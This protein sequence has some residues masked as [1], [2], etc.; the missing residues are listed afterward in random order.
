[1]REL[2]AQRVPFV[3]AVVVRAQA[4]TSV[5][6]G[7][8]AIV[9]PDGAMEGFVGGQCTE[10]S[11]RTAALGALHD[12]Q[13]V[14]LRVL[15]EGET[16]FPDA[17]GARVVINP[18][19]SGGAMEVFLEP[20]LPSPVV[21]IVGQSPIADAVANTAELLGYAA[22]RGADPTGATAVVIASHG[23]DEIE[24]IRAGLEAGIGYIGLVA[25]KRRA[26]AVFADMELTENERA[27]LRAPVGLDI[28]A[29]TAPEIAVSIMA[30]VIAAIRL[31][32]LGAAGG[33][34]S[35]TD[36][37]PVIV[38]DPVC[39]MAVT[40]G[41]DAPHAIVDGVDVWFCGDACR[42]RYLAGSEAVTSCS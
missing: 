39:G 22:Q 10:N 16:A 35:G 5:R 31:Q 24:S 11:V 19:L 13:S 6:P 28:G 7:D 3:H 29:R 38:E 30:E 8:D 33:E 42:A 27:R 15:P 20:R 23:H 26:D 14:L 12:Q 32:H 1:M 17:P 25:S 40:V 37:D 36:A 4:P 34:V 2:S 41:P 18:C 9:L 21:W